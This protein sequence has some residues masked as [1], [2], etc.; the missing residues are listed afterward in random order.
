MEAEVSLSY[1]L[2]M[3]LK[4]LL[5]A[6]GEWPFS[7]SNRSNIVLALYFDDRTSVTVL[8]GG[9][10][11]NSGIGKHCLGTLGCR[12]RLEFE[13]IRRSSRNALVQQTPPDGKSVA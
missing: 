5:N 1:A 11:R 10:C 7:C 9:R 6:A 12:L 2:V 4:V 13:G 8:Q 3:G